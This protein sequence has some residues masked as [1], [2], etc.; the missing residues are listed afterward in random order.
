MSVTNNNL[1]YVE[2]IHNLQASHAE[3]NQWYG[4]FSVHKSLH[5]FSLF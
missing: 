2:S 5:V 3:I 1:I 4:T